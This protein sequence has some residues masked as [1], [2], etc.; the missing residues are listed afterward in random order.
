[1]FIHSIVFVILAIL[2][3]TATYAAGKPISK[4]PRE[5]QAACAEQD[6]TD[7]LQ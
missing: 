4:Q 1:M 5:Q 6:T 2:S 3:A 7:N